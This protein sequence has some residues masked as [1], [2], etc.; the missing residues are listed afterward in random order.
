MDLDINKVFKSRRGNVIMITVIILSIQKIKLK[1][2]ICIVVKR[3]AKT[4]L[5]IQ[6][7]KIIRQELHLHHE[8]NSLFNQKPFYWLIK[9]QTIFNKALESRSI[10]QN[11]APAGKRLSFFNYL[12]LP[13]QE[14]SIELLPVIRLKIKNNTVEFA[15]YEAIYNNIL[16][17]LT[18]LIRKANHFLFLPE[19]FQNCRFVCKLYT[20]FFFSALRGSITRNRFPGSCGL[21]PRCK[22]CASRGASCGLNICCGNCGLNI[23]CGHGTCRGMNT[24]GGVAS[25]DN[26]YLFLIPNNSAFL[27]IVSSVSISSILFN[28]ATQSLHMRSL[29]FTITTK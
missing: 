17:H 12:K 7:S 16:V 25:T 10:P 20:C 3:K 14:F 19:I 18:L 29:L 15:Y 21:N 27:T 23:C 5:Q 9:L 22:L 4:E 2:I 24:F 26:P 8:M 1:E 11:Y 28:S 6:S 13:K